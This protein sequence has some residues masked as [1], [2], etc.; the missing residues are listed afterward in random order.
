MPTERM[1]RMYD[2]FVMGIDWTGDGVSNVSKNAVV[3]YGRRAGDPKQRLQIVYKKIFPRQDFM[4]TMEQIT[5]IANVFKVRLIGADA[6][7]GALNNAYL[8]EKLGANRVQPFRYGSFDLPVRLSQD[9]RTVYIDKTQAVDDL[10]IVLPP[11]ETFTEEAEHLLAMDTLAE[12][13]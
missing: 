13:A 8:A 9:K 1:F 5:I 7:E 6:G 10:F 2:I 11:F 12:C 3:I 4:K